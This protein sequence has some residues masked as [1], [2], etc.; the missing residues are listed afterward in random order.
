LLRLGLNRSER[1]DMPGKIALVTAAASG[2]GRAGALILAR[3]GATVAV[4][5]GETLAWGTVAARPSRSVDNRSGPRT[6][7]TDTALPRWILKA[8]DIGLSLMLS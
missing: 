2:T 4:V 7:P 3:E 1:N 6:C 8:R 5:D